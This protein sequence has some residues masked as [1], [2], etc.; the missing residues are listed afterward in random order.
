MSIKD[1]WEQAV[2]ADILPLL[3]A[4]GWVGG[5]VFLLMILGLGLIL[6]GSR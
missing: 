6:W 3:E 5:G 2:N 4:V 1:I